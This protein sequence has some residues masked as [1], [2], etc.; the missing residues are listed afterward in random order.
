M[1]EKI[2]VLS[3]FCEKKSC[4]SKNQFTWKEMTQDTN[5]KDKQNYGIT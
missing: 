5:T 2:I 1:K 4:F 3:I